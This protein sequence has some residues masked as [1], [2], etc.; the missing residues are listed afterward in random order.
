VTKAVATAG[1]FTY[2]ANSKLIYVTREGATREVP[3]SL[4]AAS[5]IWPG[6]TIRIAERHF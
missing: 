3:V 6:D 2:R 4:T 1:G 5:A